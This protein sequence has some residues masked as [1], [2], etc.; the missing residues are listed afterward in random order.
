MRCHLSRL[1]NCWK[2]VSIMSGSYRT[3]PKNILA[4]DRMPRDKKGAIIFPRIIVRKPKQGDVHPLDRKSIAIGFNAIPK[5]Y[6]YGLREIELRPRTGSMQKQAFG[7][8]YLDKRLHLYSVPPRTWEY[9]EITESYGRLVG[10]YGAKVSESTN[11]IIIKWDDSISLLMFYL[12][13]VF[14]HELGHHYAHQYKNKRKTPR[15]REINEY[16]AELYK[17]RIRKGVFGK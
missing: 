6:F 8:Y 4:T 5:E 15:G 2:T 16:L 10:R 13:E 1:A 9:A 3:L 11:G 17:S 14:F 7:R 12:M